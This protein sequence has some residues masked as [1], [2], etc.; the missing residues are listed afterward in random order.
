MNR[1]FNSTLLVLF[2]FSI[3][4]TAVLAK[5]NVKIDKKSIIFAGGCFWHIEYVFDN[6]DGVI[7]AVS[8]Y[9]G[10][11]VKNP[12]YNMVSTGKTGHFEA[13]KVV[14]NSKEISYERLLEIY[15]QNINPD[16]PLF[17]EG[18]HGSQYRY[19][20]F[21][22]NQSEK[23]LVQD[24]L[25]RLKKAGIFNNSTEVKLIKRSVFYPAESYHQNYYINNPAYLPI[26]LRKYS[27]GYYSSGWGKNTDFR[28][29]PER[30]DYW[31]GFV[32]PEKE[33]LKEILTEM[34]YYVTQSR[35]TEEPFNNEYYNNHKN[36]IYVDVVSGE[37][38]FSSRDKYDSGTGW[39]SFLRVID[40]RFIVYSET[41]LLKRGFSEVRSRYAD[42]HLGHVFKE[43]TTTGLRF[44][45]NS[46]ALKFINKD[47]LEKYG[48]GYY[49]KIFD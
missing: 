19:A 36:G 43:N 16:A 49:L 18:E 21:Y 30:P 32:K 7:E 47:L 29:F 42:S 8:G 46:A 9:T 25:T 39:P 33:E 15:F 5:N 14:Y 40:R 6:T 24:A 12:T 4:G 35:G 38:L 22:N 20:I 41:E 11:N 31:L 3:G 34:Q 44:C 1:I 10:G 45:I 28:L 37:P 2:L 48:Y 17:K 13:V 26:T 23:L 27:C